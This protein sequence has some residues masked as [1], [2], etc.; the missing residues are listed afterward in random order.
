MKKVLLFLLAAV[1]ILGLLACG[2]VAEEKKPAAEKA[3][4]MVNIAKITA[5]RRNNDFFTVLI[6]LYIG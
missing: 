1:L 6:S 5:K 3:P 4:A 2:D